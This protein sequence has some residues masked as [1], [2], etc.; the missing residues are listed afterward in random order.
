MNLRKIYKKNIQTKNLILFSN[1]EN[2]YDIFIYK[3]F[4]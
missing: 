4:A 3:K 2:R 1:S